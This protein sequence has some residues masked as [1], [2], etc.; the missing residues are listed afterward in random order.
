MIQKCEPCRPHAYQDRAYGER[1]RV[2]NLVPAKSKG[3][4][5]EW[6]CTV[7]GEPKR[8]KLK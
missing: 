4:A 7:C 5:P 2:K 1:M 8:S 6:R 3:S